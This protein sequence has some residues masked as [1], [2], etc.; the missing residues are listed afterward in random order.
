[1]GRRRLGIDDES[2]RYGGTS[3]GT[4][5]ICQPRFRRRTHLSCGPQHLLPISLAILGEQFHRSRKPVLIFPEYIGGRC[6]I[7]N[8]FGRLAACV[9][10]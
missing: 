3:A 5:L 10:S 7:S 6:G 8:M 4:L 1:M 2:K 9:L